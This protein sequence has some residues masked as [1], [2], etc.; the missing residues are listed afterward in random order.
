MPRRHG[1]RDTGPPPWEPTCGQLLLAALVS[2]L[3]TLAALLPADAPTLL[4]EVL[5]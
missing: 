2:F 3:L 4:L 5:P 1:G